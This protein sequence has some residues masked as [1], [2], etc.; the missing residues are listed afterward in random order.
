MQNQNKKIFMW[1]G[2][3]GLLML[4]LVIPELLIAQSVYPNE[5][6][7]FKTCLTIMLLSTLSVYL[8]IATIKNS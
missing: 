2:G 6:E 4:L 5:P 8:I 7:A 3:L 1:V